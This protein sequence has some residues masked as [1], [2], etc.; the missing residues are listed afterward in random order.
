MKI[1]FNKK[2][3]MEDEIEHY[4]IAICLVVNSV[5]FCDDACID[6]IE[7]GPVKEACGPSAH[8]AHGPQ[9]RHFEREG[10]CYDRPAFTT[11]R[12]VR[13]Y[14]V[15]AQ[16]MKG[17]K[18]GE[19][20]AEFCSGEGVN[21]G[22]KQVKYREVPVVRPCCF[23]GGLEKKREMI[24]LLKIFSDFRVVFF[25]MGVIDDRNVPVVVVIVNETDDS[26]RFNGGLRPAFAFFDPFEQE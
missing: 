19:V 25:D 3:E 4:F 6:K 8:A 14:P 5:E 11:A 9:V 26:A 12:H 7:C 17:E 23:L 2:S 24:D 21:P 16:Q 22:G 20:P 15:H 13:E 18:R 1:F 10:A